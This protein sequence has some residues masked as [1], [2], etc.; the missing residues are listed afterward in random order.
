MRRRGDPLGLGRVPHVGA[1]HDELVAPETGDEV[2]GPHGV[3]QSVGHGQQEL[4][5]GLMAEGVVDELEV[6]EVHEQH[7][8]GRFRPGELVLER[9]P[10]QA[11]VGQAGEAVVGGVVGQRLLEEAPFGHVLDGAD[12][13][14]GAVGRQHGRHP[15]RHPA[16]GPVGALDLDLVDFG[17]RPL[18]DS[19]EGG[20]DPGPVGGSQR[21]E[22]AAAVEAG[23]VDAEDLDAPGVGVAEP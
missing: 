9:L 10:Q 19:L 4:V 12:E 20:D 11:A 18:E 5:A 17:L 7:R 22:P 13:P 1:D 6:V 15:D 14:A 3:G 21:V 23:G 2:V 8:H 16:G